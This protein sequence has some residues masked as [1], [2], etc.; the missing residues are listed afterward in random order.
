MS[1]KS[2][3][4]PLTVLCRN[5]GSLRSISAHVR[6][7]GASAMV[8]RMRHWMILMEVLR[9]SAA[10]REVRDVRTKGTPWVVCILENY[11]K[12]R[13]PVNFE[14]EILFKAAKIAANLAVAPGD[15]FSISRN[16]INNSN[17]PATFAP[18]SMPSDTSRL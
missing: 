7:L 3:T 16:A 2:L 13:P 8:R 1:F 18:E 4:R 11:F 12:Q 5:L 6:P 17:S 15:D 9:D 10:A 14:L